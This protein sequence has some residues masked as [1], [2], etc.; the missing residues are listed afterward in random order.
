VTKVADE[1]TGRRR[2]SRRRISPKAVALGALAVVLI[3]FAALN[4]NDAGVD[5]IYDTV[6]APLI[7]VILVGALIGFVIGYLVRAHFDQD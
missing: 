2:E 1:S 5:F 3:L 6:S 4:T 7:V